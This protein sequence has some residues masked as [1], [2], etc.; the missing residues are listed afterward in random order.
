MESIM[1]SHKTILI[2]AAVFA[3]V[4]L[5]VLSFAGGP[6]S[7]ETIVV[8]TSMLEHAVNDVTGGTSDIEIVTLIPPG[9]CPGHFDL[10]PRLV[11]LI[12]R[13]SLVIRHDYQGMLEERIRKRA[14]DNINVLTVETGRSLLI[15]QEYAAFAE[16]IATAMEKSDRIG[17]FRETASTEDLTRRMSTL[18]GELQ[19]RAEPFRG[20]PVIAAVHMKPFAEWLGFDVTGV[21]K[22]PEDMSPRDIEAL[23]KT[24][25]QIIIGNLQEGTDSALT[26]GEMKGIP[27]AILSN[28]PDAP[29]YGKGIVELIEKNMTRIE[30]AWNNRLS[31]SMK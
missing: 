5:A 19:R 7:G 26:L 23:V 1:L 31:L 14:G 2:L 17:A 16:R 27:V 28:F 12:N 21:I 20:K 4:A 25:A 6:E 3:G 22:R 9:S 30:L 15:P 13:A 18:A 24:D 10:S 11:P 8:T 29:D